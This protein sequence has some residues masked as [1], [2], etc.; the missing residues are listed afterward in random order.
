M[1]VQHNHNSARLSTSRADQIRFKTHASTPIKEFSI[2][3]RSL[4]FAEVA[5]ISYLPV[6]QCKAGADKLGFKHTTHFKSNGAHAFWFQTDHD[7]VVVCRGPELNVRDDIATYAN[8]KTV[9]AETVG[10]VHGGFKREVDELWPRIE[11]ELASNHQPLWF[12]GHSIG[13]ALAMMCASRCL[14]SYIKSEPEE[15]H[16][17]GSPRVGDRQY[18]TH[19]TLR[20]FRWVNNNDPVPTFPSPLL[21]YAHSGREL[22]LD[23]LGHIKQLSGWRQINHRMGGFYRS[24]VRWRNDQLTDHSI[25][26]YIDSIFEAVRVENSSGRQLVQ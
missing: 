25:V 23:Y 17:F 20:H 13:A 21:G 15:L 3:R 22:N 24:L 11:H 12:C 16:T 26:D 5:M 6:E 4:L 1:P 2:L 10:R 8:A 9:V 7:S 14:L 18:T 19:T